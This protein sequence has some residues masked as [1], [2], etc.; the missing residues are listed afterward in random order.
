[1]LAGGMRAGQVFTDE[2]R[3]TCGASAAACCSHSPIA[4]PTDQELVPAGEFVLV[5]LRRA[6]VVD[7]D[8][9]CMNLGHLTGANLG[10]QTGIDPGECL[11]HG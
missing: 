6:L 10:R 9:T 7:V 5:L 11:P 4:T 2:E 1:M 3:N 8:I